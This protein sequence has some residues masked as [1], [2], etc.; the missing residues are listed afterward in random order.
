MRIVCEKA[1]ARHAADMHKNVERMLIKRERDQVRRQARRVVE[2]QS[3]DDDEF[4]SEIVATG[5][6]GE[7]DD[8][9]V[10]HVPDENMFNDMDDYD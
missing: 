4:D 9:S 2:C 8:T 3:S 10:E 7:A 5:D 1:V 6:V